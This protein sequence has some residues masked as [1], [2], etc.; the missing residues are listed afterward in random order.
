MIAG[1]KTEA[2]SSVAWDG[3]MDVIDNSSGDVKTGASQTLTR[4]VGEV[5]WLSGSDVGIVFNAN[6]TQMSEAIVQDL[7]VLTI[8][9][10]TTG[11]VLFTAST[12]SAFATTDFPGIGTQ[13]FAFVLDAAQILTFDASMALSSVDNRIGLLASAS[14]VDDGPDTWN[15]LNISSVTVDEPTTLTLFA[16]G[17][18]GLWFIMRRQKKV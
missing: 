11:T 3:S 18:F 8:Y 13:G 12:T 4:T 5:G 1:R 9:D 17:L 15:V 10:E 6:E 2:G 16:F 7:L 14:L